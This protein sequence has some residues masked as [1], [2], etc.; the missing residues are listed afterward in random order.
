M[1]AIDKLTDKERLTLVGFYET[2]TFKVLKK[3]LEEMRLNIAKNT[4]EM[5]T[6]PD[7]AYGDLRFMQGEAK[8]LKDLYRILRELYKEAQAN[9]QKKLKD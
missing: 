4:T 5:M 2:D 1:K 3:L 7:A 6:T 8:S 9:E